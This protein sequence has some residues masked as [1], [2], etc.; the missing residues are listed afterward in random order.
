MLNIPYADISLDLNSDICTINN[1]IWIHN[2]LVISYFNEN[3]IS[4]N[5][6]IFTKQLTSEET[7]KKLANITYL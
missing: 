5:I 7:V 6:I 3:N 2:K 1:L 4:K